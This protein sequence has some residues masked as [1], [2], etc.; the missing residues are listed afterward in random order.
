MIRERVGHQLV[1][2]KVVSSEDLAQALAIQQCEGGRL[3]SILVRMG[4]LSESTLLEF[5]SQQ[6]GV[7][8][9]ELST[10]SFDDGLLALLP[11][12]ARSA[13]FS[14]AGATIQLGTR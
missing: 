5:L 11:G 1:E 4:V 10:C 9:V 14:R 13:T 12:C 7:P 6:F 3:G 8:T 2:A